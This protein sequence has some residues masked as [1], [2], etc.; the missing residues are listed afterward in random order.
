MTIPGTPR[1]TVAR[2]F[3]TACF[4]T[5]WRGRK[6]TI[7]HICTHPASLPYRGRKKTI[8]H[9]HILHLH[10]P[11]LPYHKY[12]IYRGRKATRILIVATEYCTSGVRLFWPCSGSTLKSG[13]PWNPAVKVSVVDVKHMLR[14]LSVRG[15]LNR[16]KGIQIRG[17]SL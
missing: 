13:H 10:T 12:I 1:S 16:F 2:F 8:L 5:T 11:Q 3:Y 17:S 15:D 4:P 7:L 14:L 9:L 6:A